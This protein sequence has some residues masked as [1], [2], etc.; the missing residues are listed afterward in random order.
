MPSLSEIEEAAREVAR[1]FGPTPQ[2]EWPMLSEVVGTTSWLKH[3]N[4][5]PVGAFKIRGGLAYVAGLVDSGAL[6][7]AGGGTRGLVCA[8]RGNHGQSLAYAAARHGLELTIVVPHG[9]SREKN[10]AMNALGARLIEHGDD[11]QASLEHAADLATDRDLH[12]VPSYDRGLVAGVA[13][14][15]LELMRAVPDLDAVYVPIGLGSGICGLLAARDALDRD[16]EIVGVVSAHAPAYAESLASG[17]AVS[18]P[19]STALADGMACRTPNA[20][21]FAVMRAKVR[22]IVRVTDEQV[23][24]AMRVIFATTHNVAEGAGAAAVAAVLADRDRV[25]GR[26][27]AAVL[28]GGNVDSDVFAR[29]LAGRE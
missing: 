19:V 29:V 6:E 27:V 16:V 17:Q 2:Q 13:T 5:T 21:A 26:T 8:T 1:A 23:A 28:S 3:E 10:A 24:E 20:Q 4:H 9:N 11:F 12:L 15:G 22:R 14:Y 25:R 7:R 18:A